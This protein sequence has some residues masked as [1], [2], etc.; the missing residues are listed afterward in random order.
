MART[1]GKTH[2]GEGGIHER[3]WGYFMIDAFFLVTQ[4]FV[5]TFQLRVADDVVLPNNLLPGNRTIVTPPPPPK[6]A[7][8]ITV[9]HGAT[10]SKYQMNGGELL[11]EQG[12]I[13]RL[14]DV[15]NGKSPSKFFVKV[16]Y[17]GEVAF[18][19]VMTIF[20]ACKKLGIPECGLQPMRPRV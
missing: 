5:L 11:D 1:F 15:V 3:P 13:A 20:N 17:D 18:K 9:L 6:T 16:S 12:V 10:G 4:F 7:V 19:D 2:G 8:G 14:G